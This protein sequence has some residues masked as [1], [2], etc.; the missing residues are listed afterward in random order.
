M[1]TWK[2]KPSSYTRRIYLISK[3]ES[4]RD[5]FWDLC[6]NDVLEITLQERAKSIA[7]A[8]DLALIVSVDGKE[9]LMRIA[10][11]NLMRISAWM[12]KKQLYVATKVAATYKTAPTGALQAITRIPPIDLMAQ[13][14]RF[15]YERKS[16]E[17]VRSVK[18][19]TL[20]F[21]EERW[22]ENWFTG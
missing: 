2:K 17:T 6:Y 12:D 3:Q 15:I 9:D 7:F 22:K 14:R 10:N 1:T 16:E 21:W 20:H 8:D 13:E 18:S 5:L 4:P 19:R 11:D